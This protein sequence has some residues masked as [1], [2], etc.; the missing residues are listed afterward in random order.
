MARILVIDDDPQIRMLLRELL[1]REAYEVLDAFNGFEALEIFSHNTID[2][3]I[4]DIVMPDMDG[5]EVMIRLRKT[6]PELKVIA[7]SGG[8]RIRP[9]SYLDLAD[10]LGADA[11]LTKPMDMNV[12]LKTVKELLAG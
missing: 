3:V 8:A 5:L 2:L 4:T 12:V 6:H 9:Q 7:I 10:S 11:T 1:E